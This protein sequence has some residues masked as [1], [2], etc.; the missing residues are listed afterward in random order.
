MNAGPGPMYCNNNP[1]HQE[2]LND[3]INKWTYVSGNIAAKQIDMSELENALEQ[4]TKTG[5]KPAK[6]IPKVQDYNFGQ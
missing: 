2:L 4:V 3:I 5:E 6:I 1:Y